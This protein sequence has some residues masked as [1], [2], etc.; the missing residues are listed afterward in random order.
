TIGALDSARK[1]LSRY[2]DF[3]KNLQSFGGGESSGEADTIIDQALAGFEDALDDDLNISAALG[4]VFDL[5]RDINRLR[6]EN[7]LSTD[8]RDRA[9]KAVEKIDVV[10]NILN[11]DTEG[12]DS[13]IED[14]INKRT[15]AK[16]NKDFATADK[17]R[18][19]LLKEGIILEDSSDG[20]KWKRKL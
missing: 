20:T 18:D 5:V 8:E 16:K 11:W 12:I 6:A 1:T 14:L 13:E 7:K 17:I 10:L 4:E 2:T 3:Y 9:I 15:E 19:D